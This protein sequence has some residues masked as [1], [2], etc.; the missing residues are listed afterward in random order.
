[1]MQEG[2]VDQTPISRFIA[3]STQYLLQVRVC[4]VEPERV[5]LECA[6]RAAAE[7]GPAPARA[8]PRVPQLKL[9]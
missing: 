5:Q 1:M 4:A 2:F 7:R 3:M 9:V 6:D 8:S